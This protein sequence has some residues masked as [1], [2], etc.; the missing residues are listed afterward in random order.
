[1]QGNYLQIDGKLIALED[2]ITIERY[3]PF[4][5]NTGVLLPASAQYVNPRG[6]YTQPFKSNDD[7]L[8]ELTG[9]LDKLQS[10]N[11]KSTF[12][13]ARILSNGQVIDTG[14][15]AVQRVTKNLRTG[16]KEYEGILFNNGADW[17]AA[18]TGKTLKNL[19]MNTGGTTGI[20]IRNTAEGA[21]N[22]IHDLLAHMVQH[23]QIDLELDFS[24]ADGSIITPET[25][26]GIWSYFFEDPTDYPYDYFQPTT[27]YANMVNEEGNDYFCFPTY[28]ADW[29]DAGTDSCCNHFNHFGGMTLQYDGSSV[30]PPVGFVVKK[31]PGYTAVLK[32]LTTPRGNPQRVVNYTPLRNQIV[33]MFY[34]HQ[35]LRHC[36]LEFGYTVSGD[37]INDAEFK[38]IVVPNTYSIL[39]EQVLT[40]KNLFNLGTDY[41]VLYMQTPTSIIAS[42]H[43]PAMNVV[44]FVRDFMMKFNCSITFEGINAVIK[45]NQLQIADTSMDDIGADVQVEFP[46][47]AQPGIN[48]KYNYPSGDKSY[49]AQV[50]YAGNKPMTNT[51]AVYGSGPYAN[52]NVFPILPYESLFDNADDITY[53]Q[54][55][56]Q[57]LNDSGRYQPFVNFI[58]KS[59]G[60]LHKV[61]KDNPYDAA[62]IT[63]WIDEAMMLADEAMVLHN[64]VAFIAGAINTNTSAQIQSFSADVIPVETLDYADYKLPVMYQQGLA[65]SYSNPL[66]WQGPTDTPNYRFMGTPSTGAE[67]LSLTNLAIYKPG[68]IPWFGHT[69]TYQPLGTMVAEFNRADNSFSGVPQSVNNVTAELLY[70]PMVIGDEEKKFSIF[71]GLQPTPEDDGFVFPFMTFN[72]YVEMN[73]NSSLPTIAPIKFNDWNLS[74]TGSEG[75]VLTFWNVM[76]KVFINNKKVTVTANNV[77]SDFVKNFDFTR[78]KIIR[79]RKYY[80]ASIKL[81][82]PDFFKTKTAVFECYEL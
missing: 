72:N 26:S 64:L 36:F 38:K 9:H 39:R 27:A 32:E 65:D 37:L 58:V 10:S 25:T 8:D 66:G 79:G 2:G 1:M 76:L 15:F 53:L 35:V 47:N 48:I 5:D 75:L 16:K 51:E 57:A 11:V 29:A 34:Y 56:L 54:N 62:I 14:T 42:N 80:V 30:A 28:Y 24:Y 18:V 81:T 70:P 59:L 13:Q 6:N 55:Y 71:A 73:D 21:A 60:A 12:S 17:V 3:S 40:I 20:Q 41:N 67:S 61:I 77:P 50:A 44:D 22:D 31:Y 82:I 68:A 4:I 49:D 46:A 7:Q 69:P 23:F 78:S 45:R 43:L 74:L 19:I 33:P 63:N 52:G